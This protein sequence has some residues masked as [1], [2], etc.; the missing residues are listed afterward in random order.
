MSKLKLENTERGFGRA[1]FK[2]RYGANCSIQES[3][4]A[5]EDCIWLGV[6]DAVP[7]M[8]VR[9]EGWQPVP[10]PQVDGVRI[11]AVNDSGRMHLNREQVAA[12]LPLLK[13]FVKTGRLK[14]AKRD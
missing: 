1:E 4:L 11:V 3:S 2:D 7:Q 9:G 8:L 6:N 14:N 10:L 12:L 13:R 5:T